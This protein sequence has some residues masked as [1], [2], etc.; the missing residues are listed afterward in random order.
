M[1]GLPRTQPVG[2]P[3][4]DI[5]A[6]LRRGATHGVLIPCEDLIEAANRIEELT[7]ALQSVSDALP[8]G[9]VLT[10]RGRPIDHTQLNYARSLVDGALAPSLEQEKSHG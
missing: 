4:R 2:E 5:V 8:L 10:W 7:K 6:R 3:A 1:T 9:I